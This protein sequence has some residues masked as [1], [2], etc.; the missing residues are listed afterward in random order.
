MQLVSFTSV[1]WLVCS[2]CFKN[3]LSIASFLFIFG[4][5]KQTIQLL[6]QLNAKNY[7]SGLKCLDSKGVPSRSMH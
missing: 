5:F 6:Q 2:T 4:K 1:V 7:P 3:G